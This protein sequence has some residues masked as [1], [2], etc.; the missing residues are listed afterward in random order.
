MKKANDEAIMKNPPDYFMESEDENIR[1]D[2]KTDPD[3]LKRQA[4][5]CGVQSGMRILD[6]GCGPGVT[7]A[8]L[9]EMVG[10]YGIVTGV[11]YSSERIAYARHHYGDRPGVAFDLHDL[12]ESCRRL[13]T[14]DLI[15]ARFVLE[16]HLSSARRIVANL[17]ECL[18]PGGVLCL[19]DLDYNC[20]IHYD[21]P[22]SMGRIVE[23]VMA[24]MSQR[25]DFDPFV[26]RKLYSMLYDA[27]LKQIS[28]DVSAHNVFYGVLKQKDHFNI[29]KK[30]EIAAKLEPQLLAGY[31]GGIERFHRDF[32]AFL[33]DPRRFSYTPLILCRGQKT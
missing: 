23:N 17:I 1:L 5:W 20:L 19:L 27:G 24:A 8:L 22:E 26:G 13:G 29:M 21:P 28:V 30:L 11:D 2:V 10:P 16:Y 6:A 7:T 18:K 4:L 32:E 14:F 31:P 9:A 33:L 12:R 25:Y 15:W 3:A